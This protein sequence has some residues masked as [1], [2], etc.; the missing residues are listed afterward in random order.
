VATDIEAII[1]NIGSCF[2]FTGKS[3]IHVGAGG[4]QFIG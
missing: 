2:D 4:G 3:V 1:R